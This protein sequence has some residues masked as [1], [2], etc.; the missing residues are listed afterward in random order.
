[1]DRA[2]DDIRIRTVGFQELASTATREAAEHVLRSADSQ[3]FDAACEAC[4]QVFE[5]G[6][7]GL[8]PF[9]PNKA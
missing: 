1:M 4:D 6:L 2:L 3:N 9:D 7:E 5:N 8:P